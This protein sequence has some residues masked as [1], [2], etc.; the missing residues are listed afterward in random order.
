MDIELAV[1]AMEI[2]GHIDHMVLFSGDGDFRSLVEAVQRRGV[3]V[4]VVSTIT[5]QPPMVADELRRQA[6]VFTD[7]ITLQSKIGREPGERAARGPRDEREAS[8]H[9]PQFLQRPPAPQRADAE[10]GADDDFDE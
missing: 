9:T 1:D 10:V 4:T 2:A 8:Q 6:D 5:T 7:I 3:R